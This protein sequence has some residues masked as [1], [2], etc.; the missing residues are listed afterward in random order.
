MPR[1]SLKSIVFYAVTIAPLCLLACLV[2]E[3]SWNLY[4]AG[5]PDYARIYNELEAC[6]KSDKGEFSLASGEGR[7]KIA[8]DYRV[9]GG[10]YKPKNVDVP[11]APDQK[12]YA[13]Y[14]YG[15]SPVV[16]R[17]PF[18]S[19]DSLFSSILQATLNS[20]P[21]R[22]VR[23][24]NFEAVSFDSFDIRG[25]MKCTVT[26]RRPDL[27]IYYEGHMDYMGAYITA[28]RKNF[29]LLRGGWFGGLLGLSVLNR[30]DQWRHF[31]EVGDWLVYSSLEPR[32]MNFLQ[33]LGVIQ[34]DPAP[35]AEYDR[36]ILSYYKKNVLDMA[37]FAAQRGIPI[38]FIT[39]IDNMEAK[40][41]G[42]PTVTQKNFELGLK[43]T[44]YR[45]R[46]EYLAKA[47]DSEIFTAD[48]RAKSGLN[49]FLRSLK[50]EGVYVL[51]LEGRLR[52][53]KFAFD[54]DY[55]YDVSHIRPRLHKIIAKHLYDFMAAH[56]LTTRRK[57]YR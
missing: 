45:R 56:G 47:V 4:R 34:L 37:A 48:M 35:F 6:L 44:D 16:S 42:I 31:A 38:I 55:F 23:V 27:M 49:A 43:E 7:L 26:H 8:Y 57:S 30:Y 24:Y 12:D 22:R 28:I 39:P 11:F 3:V 36:V 19:A 46:M 41:Y 5:H 32:L 52:Q 18:I 17:L 53:E 25:L 2:C 40:P 14:L 50:Q 33:R 29:R 10:P 13:V 54:Y 1:Y 15:S 51:D 21:G 20:S 9:A